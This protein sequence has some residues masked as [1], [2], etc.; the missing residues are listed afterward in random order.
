MYLLF[1]RYAAQ[2]NTRIQMNLAIVGNVPAAFRR[3]VPRIEQNFVLVGQVP[4][5]RMPVQDT[6]FSPRQNIRLLENAVVNE[7][8]GARFFQRQQFSVPERNARM[9]ADKSVRF[10]VKRQ[11]VKP[12][13]RFPIEKGSVRK[14]R[15]QFF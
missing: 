14:I 10:Y 1:D 6:P 15:P 9:H 4:H 8:F 12:V 7:L 13:H 11:Q 3:A 5:G 2:S